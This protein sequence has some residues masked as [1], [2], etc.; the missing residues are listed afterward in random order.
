[1]A[2]C[3]T[4]SKVE[5]VGLGE[6]IH[7]VQQTSANGMVCFRPTCR[8]RSSALIRNSAYRQFFCIAFITV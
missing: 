1:M 4:V 5:G 3:I 6:I 2:S 8:R 7:S